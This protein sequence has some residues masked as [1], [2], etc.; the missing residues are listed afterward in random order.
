MV[1]QAFERMRTHVGVLRKH[2]LVY[3]KMA[4]ITFVTTPTLLFS[5]RVLKGVASPDGQWL[6]R[7]MFHEYGSMIVNVPPKLVFAN[8]CNANTLHQGITPPQS[9]CIHHD[10]V[11]LVCVT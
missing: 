3:G 4:I 11:C 5:L 8:T 2:T 9:V 10:A 7:R 6:H 1:S